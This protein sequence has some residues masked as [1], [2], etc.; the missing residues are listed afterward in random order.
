MPGRECGQIK[1]SAM[2]QTYQL[3]RLGKQHFQQDINW[4]EYTSGN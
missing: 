3:A 1:P 4:P 2:P